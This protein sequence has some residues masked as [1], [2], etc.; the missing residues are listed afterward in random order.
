[1]RC[2][3]HISVCILANGEWNNRRRKHMI[4][5]LKLSRCF[6]VSVDIRGSNPNISAAVGVQIGSPVGAI[7]P[8]R[9][10]EFLLLSGSNVEF[11]YWPANT[12]H[13]TVLIDGF[14]CIDR[15]RE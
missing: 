13:E 8:I 3:P 9:K 7:S 11:V 5:L 1:M 2:D 6:S 4:D 14:N 15:M 12:K 10:F